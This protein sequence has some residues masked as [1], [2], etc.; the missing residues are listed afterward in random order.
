[1]ALLV[2]FGISEGAAW[3][4]E[5]TWLGILVA[6]IMLTLAFGI[7]ILYSKLKDVE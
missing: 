3:I 4:I 6:G 7:I 5:P 2:I 1:V